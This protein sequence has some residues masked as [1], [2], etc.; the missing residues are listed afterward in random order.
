[1]VGIEHE[2]Q[3]GTPALSLSGV[4]YA[5]PGETPLIENVSFD[6]MR[7]EFVAFLA[8]SGIGKSTLFRLIAGLLEPQAGEIRL[9][10][11]AA[12]G[13]IG[14]GTGSGGNTAEPE[15]A[16]SPPGLH[17]GSRLGRVGFM[18]QRDCLMP[19]RTVLDNA[20]LGLELAGMPRREARDRVR[21]VLPSFGLK[22]TEA[23]YPGELSG[24]MR[25]RVSF[26]RT[27]L[28]GSDIL[29]LDEPF[30]ALDALTRVSMQ[31]WLLDIWERQRKTVLFI[32]HDIDEA[33]LLSD[34]V[35]I[36]AGAPI[37]SLNEAAVPISRPRSYGAT[38]EAPFLA[39]KKQV[40]AMLRKDGGGCL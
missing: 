4:T 8:P 37:R 27:A 25:Q 10:G 6:V 11:A 31:E 1:M 13:P 3:N 20:A 38:M 32:T 28:C 19:W 24:G 26:L 14:G 29:L 34:R 39:L 33:L 17:A 22:G 35:L 12:E 5:F 36:A 21:E 30:S 23:M 16:G 40:L 9:G 7:G 2:W 18:P 15:A